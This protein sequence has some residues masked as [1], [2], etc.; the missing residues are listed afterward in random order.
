VSDLRAFK[1]DRLQ[2]IHSDGAVIRV[3]EV[4]GETLFGSDSNR[5]VVLDDRPLYPSLEAAQEAADDGVIAAG[6]ICDAGC[7]HWRS[8]R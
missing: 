6:H 2:R 3:Y 1:I 7:Y 8:L 5:E 4:V